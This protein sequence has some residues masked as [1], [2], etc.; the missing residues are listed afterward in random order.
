MMCSRS[1][2]WEWR[3]GF[4]FRHFAP[5]LDGHRHAS[6]SSF[7]AADADIAA[8]FHKTRH[9]VCYNMPIWN[10]FGHDLMDAATI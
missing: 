2:C 1:V 6:A 4:S 9:A 7:Y 5:K 3:I 10:D 8:V